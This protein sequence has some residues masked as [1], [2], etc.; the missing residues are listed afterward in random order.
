MKSVRFFIL[1]LLSSLYKLP[2][3]AFPGTGLWDNVT[4]CTYCPTQLIRLRKL[5][6][7]TT[8]SS[9]NEDFKELCEPPEIIFTIR[10]VT[11]QRLLPYDMAYISKQNSPWKVTEMSQAPNPNRIPTTSFPPCKNFQADFAAHCA[12]CS[13]LRAFVN[14]SCRG[15]EMSIIN[16]VHFNNYLKANT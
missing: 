7:F 16:Q 13:L 10:L 6:K 3:S 5:V 2:C 15:E 9:C 12:I 8:K 1:S 14:N 4:S 11:T